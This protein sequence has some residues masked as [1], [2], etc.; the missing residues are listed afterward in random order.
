MRKEIGFLINDWEEIVQDIEKGKFNS[1]TLQAWKRCKDLNIAPKNLNFKFLSDKKLEEKQQNNKDLIDAFQ[2]QFEYARVIL[3]ETPYVLALADKEGWIIDIHGSTKEF[4]GRDAGVALGASWQEKDIGNNG[5]GTA[6]VEKKPVLVYSIEHY[7]LVYKSGVCFGIPIRNNGEIIGALDISVPKEYAQPN[8]LIITETIVKSI[9]NNLELFDLKKNHIEKVNDLDGFLISLLHE[10][11]TPLSTIF[12]T[13][14]L[15]NSKNNQN[16]GLNYNL[17]E[18]NSYRLMK[19]VNNLTDIYKIDKGY[20]KIQKQNENII[21]IINNL[22]TEVN[23]YISKLNIKV[24][25]EINTSI[26][27]IIASID[28]KEFR[29]ALL[30][31]LSNAVKASQ[32]GD[33]IILNVKVKYGYINISIKD[34]GVGIPENNQDKI[35]NKYFR[36][37]SHFIR[38]SEGTGAGLYIVKNIVDLH[39]GKIS[40]KSQPEKGS[41]F[42]IKLPLKKVSDK[43]SDFN[44]KTYHTKDISEQ[45]KIEFSDLY[46]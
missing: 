41:T 12:S 10:F 1:I 34:N 31:L 16:Q 26:K 36:I 29:R 2:D 32:Y 37:D 21:K 44:D 39:Q 23:K 6:L 25:T 19:L 15:F 24:E 5:I 46:F 8:R 18:K 27:N 11:R 17:I 28:K 9:E 3:S 40:L 13:L 45:I 20:F 38:N 43:I 35:F 42:I 30:N 14:S 33:I 4:G 22:I 7:G